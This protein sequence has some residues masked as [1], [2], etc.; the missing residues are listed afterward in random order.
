MN[1]WVKYETRSPKQD[2]TSSPQWAVVPRNL[3]GLDVVR[4][5]KAGLPK[6]KIYIVNGILSGD[7]PD[8]HVLI[9][10]IHT[11]SGRAVFRNRISPFNKRIVLEKLFTRGSELSSGVYFTT[12]RE[13][14]TDVNMGLLT[15]RWIVK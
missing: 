5:N 11:L 8:N 7:L 10:E 12:I 6:R 3:S 15:A 13:E 2:Y 14:N 4:K 1:A 9:I